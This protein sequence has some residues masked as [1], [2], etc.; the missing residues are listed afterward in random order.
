MLSWQLSTARLHYLNASSWLECQI[1]KLTSH[2]GSA[3]RNIINGTSL[4]I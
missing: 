1:S 2:P 4:N 3:R